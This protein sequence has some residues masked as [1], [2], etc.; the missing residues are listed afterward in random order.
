M[1]WGLQTKANPY[2]LA[3]I[4][5]LIQCV[6]TSLPA[7][8]ATA[9]MLSSLILSPP[10]R[11]ASSLPTLLIAIP[12]CKIASLESSLPWSTAISLAA[13]DRIT[14][15]AGGEV[16]EASKLNSL[17]CLKLARASNWKLRGATPERTMNFH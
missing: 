10:S 6:L 7:S 17:T 14:W 15:K 2:I 16:R 8:R 12:R 4:L 5:R 1:F 3:T 13:A 9:V 11:L